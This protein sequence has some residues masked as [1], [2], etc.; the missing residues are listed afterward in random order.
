MKFLGIRFCRVAK[1]ENAE[2]LAKMLGETGLGLKAVDMPK[3]DGLDGF[4]GAVFPVEDNASNSWIEIWPASEQ[5]PEMVMLQ[6]IVDDADAWAENARANGLDPKGPDDA[7]GER[8]YYIEGPS[9]L[10]I[11]FVSKAS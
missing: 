7:H 3:I 5:M 4:Q 11:A 1:R 6:I 9:G 2:G 10:P 8:I